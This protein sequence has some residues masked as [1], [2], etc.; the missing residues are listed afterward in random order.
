MN[1]AGDEYDRLAPGYQFPRLLVTRTRWSEFAWVGKQLLDML[2]LFQSRQVLRRADGGHDERSIHRRLAQR[3][4]L[5]AVAGFVELVKVTKHLVPAS[6][7]T[8]IAGNKTKHILRS[9]DARGLRSG[10][11]VMLTSLTTDCR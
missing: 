10:S 3:F 9:W 11:W 6:E 1:P 4:E 2:V 7:L 8:V 5:Y